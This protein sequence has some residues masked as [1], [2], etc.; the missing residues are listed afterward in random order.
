LNPKIQN[1]NWHTD[2]TKRNK[3][4]SGRMDRTTT[5]GKK[6]LLSGQSGQQVKLKRYT[7]LSISVIVAAIV[8]VSALAI[9]KHSSQNSSKSTL[10][11]RSMADMPA[12]NSGP[13]STNTSGGPQISFPETEYD[14]GTISQG[15]KVS[16]TFVVKNTG[17]APLR[18]IKAQGT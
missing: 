18:L 10:I 17:D 12:S 9:F 7:I 1:E 13:N 15:S 6:Q 14:F 2:M 3:K 8:V 5:K 11:N 16:H 4:K